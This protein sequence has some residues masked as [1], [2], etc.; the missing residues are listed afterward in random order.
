MIS[1]NWRRLVPAV[2]A[3]ASELMLKDVRPSP[4]FDRRTGRR[5]GRLGAIS[6][7]EFAH[8]LLALGSHDR[9]RSTVFPVCSC[10]IPP[11]AAGKTIVRFGYV[12]DDVLVAR[13]VRVAR[14]RKFKLFFLFVVREPPSL[15]S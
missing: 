7:P 13:T 9:I 5:L 14:K 6:R 11:V 15:A 8:S 10:A 3:G 12:A 1:V 4:S 2:K